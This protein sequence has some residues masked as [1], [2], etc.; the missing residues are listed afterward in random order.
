V[1]SLVVIQEIHI[2]FIG[3]MEPFNKREKNMLD[4]ANEALF[5][6]LIYFMIMFTDF[7]HD[8]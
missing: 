1:Q 7:V 3:L 8:K 2:I 5:M 4:K 6:V